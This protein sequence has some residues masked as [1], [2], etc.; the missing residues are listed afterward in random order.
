MQKRLLV[1]VL[2]SLTIW[3]WGAPAHALIITR[4]D[5]ASVAANLSAGDK[6]FADAAF[7]YAAQQ[8]QSLYSDPVT[9]NITMAATPGTGTLGG[10]STV[11][12]GYYSYAQIRTALINDQT[13]HPSVDG[14]TSVG[15]LPASDSKRGMALRRGID[16]HPA[17]RTSA[18]N[19]VNSDIAHLPFNL[20][21]A[22]E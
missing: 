8:F 5:A 18:G 1:V 3:A 17:P 11:L 21:V 19:W 2:S 20:G 13:N 9:I 10:S 4:T 12:S 7:D 6:V 22:H 15:T 16:S 14:A